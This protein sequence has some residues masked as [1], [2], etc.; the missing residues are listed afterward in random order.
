MEI[1]YEVAQ[2]CLFRKIRTVSRH[3]TNLYT[4]MLKEI[5]V[6]PVQFS[7]MTAIEIL[8]EPNISRFSSAMKM[9]RTTINRNIKPLVRDG[10]VL[11][12]QSED[13]REKIVMLTEEGRSIYIKGY[14]SWKNAQKTLQNQ[15]G[16]ENWDSINLVL[17][18]IIN[19][20]SDE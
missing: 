17:D 10:L 4:N 18:D 2:N 20:I 16:K 15:I 19:L 6:T 14:E 11:I 1:Y 7:M 9:D 3:V 8:Q 5:G 13:K 12:K